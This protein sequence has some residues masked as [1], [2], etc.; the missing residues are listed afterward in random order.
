MELI[1]EIESERDKKGKL[2]RY[3]I[4]LC[5]YCLQES[6]KDLYVGLKAKSCGCKK[7]ELIGKANKGKKRTEEQ[8]NKMIIS[9]K[10][11][12]QKMSL[13]KMGHI[14]TKETRCK[15]SIANK[16]KKQSKETIEKRVQKVKGKK[17]KPCSEE[18]KIK[19][20]LANKGKKRTEEQ[21]KNISKTKKGKK[22]TQEH[23][24]KIG[25]GNKGKSVSK[26]S[27]NKMSFS[28]KGS[29]NYN[30][31]NG[32]SFEPYGLEFNKELKLFIL[33]RDNYKCQCPN[34]KIINPKKLHIHHIDYDKTNNTPENLITLCGS[35]HT[36]TNNL[37][38]REYWIDFYQNIMR[39]KINEKYCGYSSD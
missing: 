1:R 18:R 12:A 32:S 7:N 11:I 28:K 24:D 15:I 3:A 39:N 30:W 9:Q 33:E 13:I 20:S 10:E 34:C 31:N 37:I 19:I 16:G 26:E 4:F 27:R 6:I 21:R 2:R 25:R 17:R 36:K 38:K 23:K 35:C 29:K 14:T 22:L 8:R 5:P